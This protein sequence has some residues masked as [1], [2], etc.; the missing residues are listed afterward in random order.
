MKLRVAEQPVPGSPGFT[1]SDLV[2][3]G[4]QADR[5]RR[6]ELL[7]EAQDKVSAPRVPTFSTNRP[8]S[9]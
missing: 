8:F 7:R 2:L 4:V 5:R 6:Q 9:P 1:L 3:Q